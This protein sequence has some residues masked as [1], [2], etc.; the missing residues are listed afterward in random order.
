M[1]EYT[2]EASRILLVD[3][4]AT[5]LAVL[6][7]AIQSE[8]WTTLFATDGETA[9]EQAEY[10]QPNLILLDVMMP[11][12]DGFETCRRL[13]AN[14][15][16]QAIPIIF[17]TALSDPLDKVK[18]FN[19]GAVDYITKPF[20]QEEVT[21]RVS[22]QLKLHTLNRQLSQQN[23][24]LNQTIEKQAQTEAQLQ[25][26]T[27]ELEKKIE[28]R[29]AEL[30]QALS[31]LQQNQSYMVQSE[32]MSALGQMVAGIAHEINNPVNFIYGNLKH[33]RNYY[34]ELIEVIEIY[35][36]N[37]PTP[38]EELQAYLDD[39]DLV[40]TTQD[41][42]K[43]LDSL[44]IGADRIRQ[45]VLSLRNF[46]RLDEATVKAVDIHEG[47]ESTLLILNHRLR[48]KAGGSA[49]KVVKN[50]CQMPL[51]ECY[52]SQLNQV[53]MNILANAI[54][55]IEET[56]TDENSAQPTEKVIEIRTEIFEDNQL[57][58]HITNS[59]SVIPEA[60]RAKLFDPFFTT[61]DI[62]KGTGL[63]L[64]ISYQIVVE[65]HSGQIKCV[66]APTQGTC[67]TIQL[68]MKQ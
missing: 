67:F 50:Y 16:T 61:K 55:A 46:S 51:I 66:S 36:K 60:I 15:A 32:K 5:N 12:I 47:I 53:F 7:E 27:Q 21:A 35:Q 68:P 30:T 25:V 1:K 44:A 17:M 13:K 14:P 52:P 41:T 65:K 23:K 42:L 3:D 34:Q 59:G 54:D 48:G 39:I 45:I 29:T 2:A 22:I 28:E 20:Q 9:I 40:F 58:I 19:L 11:G 37:Y 8:G 6:S 33:A 31:R 64:S 4:T 38:S 26:L 10:A 18:G 62:G 24:L 63:G 57:Q 49:I 56:E 43:L